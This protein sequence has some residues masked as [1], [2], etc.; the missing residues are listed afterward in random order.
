M[1]TLYTC[2]C[3]NAGVLFCELN[4]KCAAKAKPSELHQ[5]AV[6]IN[7]ILLFSW[8]Q[9]YRIALTRDNGCNLLTNS[10]P[11]AGQKLRYSTALHT[12]SL[13][14]ICSMLNSGA[15]AWNI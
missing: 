11:A 7:L 3:L 1:D 8:L 15:D 14:A 12:N 10:L 2:R 9:A 5:L 4:V 6:A 13:L